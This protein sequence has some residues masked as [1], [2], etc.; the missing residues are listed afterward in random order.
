[1]VSC[2]VM[3]ELQSENGHISML[4]SPRRK[5]FNQCL[6]QWRKIG[7][8]LSL[9]VYVCMCVCVWCV[10]GG[11]EWINIHSVYESLVMISH[12]NKQL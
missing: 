10:C 3:E 7:L 4:F 8:E 1:M 2:L 9:C 5:Y 12:V 11:G 6:D